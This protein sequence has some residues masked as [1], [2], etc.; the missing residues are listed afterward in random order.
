MDD[1]D[2]ETAMPAVLRAF[3]ARVK[4]DELLGPTFNAA[5]HDWDE[6][7]DHTDNFGHR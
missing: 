5:A 7:L 2:I 4:S 1:L 3:Y 6:H